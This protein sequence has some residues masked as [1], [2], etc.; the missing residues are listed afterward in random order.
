MIFTP[1]WNLM[2]LGATPCNG[3]LFDDLQATALRNSSHLHAR[4]DQVNDALWD[5][6]DHLKFYHNF[7]PHSV[8]DGHFSEAL[9][10]LPDQRHSWIELIFYGASAALHFDGQ[11]S[12]MASRPSAPSML[13]G[14]SKDGRSRKIQRSELADV[15]VLQSDC[16]W[17]GFH[18][19]SLVRHAWLFLA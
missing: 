14:R 3:C 17:L 19:F 8:C 5:R 4:G 16:V 7:G 1:T 13:R 6:V 2:R 15:A 12:L 11:T 9:S 10:I 18:R